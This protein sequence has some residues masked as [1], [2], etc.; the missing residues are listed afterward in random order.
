MRNT[1]R[2]GGANA[3]REMEIMRISERAQFAGKDTECGTN[4]SMGEIECEG[5]S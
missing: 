1:A 5:I 3:R 4:G 2:Q